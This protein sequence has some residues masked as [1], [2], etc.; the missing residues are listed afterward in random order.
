V[1]ERSVY[2]SFWLTHTRDLSENHNAKNRM[3][4]IT[5]ENEKTGEN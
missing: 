5:G 4:C 1:T 3:P 2:P